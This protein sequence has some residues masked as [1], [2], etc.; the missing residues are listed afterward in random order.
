MLPPIAS[1]PKRS[2]AFMRDVSICLV[3]AA[4]RDRFKIKPTGRSVRTRSGCSIVAEALAV[5]HMAVGSKAIETIWK[6]YGHAM[7]TVPGWASSL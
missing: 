3:V 7:P 2:N 6:K 4:V 1:G 5:I